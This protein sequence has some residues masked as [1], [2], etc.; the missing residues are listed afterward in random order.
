LP[1]VRL[2]VPGVGLSLAW[3][4]LQS[5]FYADTFVAPWTTVAANR[6]HCTGGDGVL[7]LAAF[8]I[9]ALYWGRSWM[10][11]AHWAPRLAFPAVGVAYTT[12][13]EYVK[14]T[15]FKVRKDLASYDDPGWYAHP[16][17]TVAEVANPE[18][19]RRDGIAV[20]PTAAMPAPSGVPQGGHHQH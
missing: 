17:G 15:V 9:S 7:L 20:P 19:L 11:K 18:T 12:G 5:P 4:V 16:R 10:Q 6:L 13:N 14:L 3:E 2:L 1:E 8:W